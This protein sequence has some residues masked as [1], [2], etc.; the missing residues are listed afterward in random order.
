[1]TPADLVLVGHPF[2]AIGM[3][4]HV[5]S[6]FRAFRAAGLTPGLIDIYGMDRNKDPDFEREFAGHVVPT[7]S[8]K[9]NLF[10]INADEVEQAM[11]VLEHLGSGP[12]FQSAYNIIYPAWELANY[13]E[14]WAKILDRFDEV[15]APSR[16]IQDAITPVTERP[17]VH[18]PLAVELTMSSFLGRRHFGIPE[19]AFVCLFFFDFSSYAE[20]KNPFAM[21]E[22][23]EKLVAARPHAPLH[24][25][26]KYK[27]GDDGNPARKA[28]EARLKALGGQAQAITRQLSDNE[29]KNLVRCCD[30]FVS[31]HRSEGFGRGPAEA[32]IMGRA[33]VATNYSGNLDFMTP[34]TSLLV[35][36]ELIPVAEGAYLFGEGQVWAD[37]SVDHAVELIGGLLDD[38]RSRRDLGERARRHIRTNF[39]NRATGL[40]YAARLEA[41]A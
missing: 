11:G 21:L 3:A 17:V 14:P 20:R 24:A 31:L 33:A 7:L 16:F 19:D 4:E 35:D 12:A 25:V 38:P 9:T 23:F 40:R 13:P 22:A 30:A 1:M 28:L 15:W 27:G 32:M 10:C 26:V 39:S 6:A 29:I 34:D 18:M 5:R 8:P 36:C 41:L 2:S 37:P